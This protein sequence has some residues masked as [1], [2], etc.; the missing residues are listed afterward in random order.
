MIPHLTERDIDDS[1]AYKNKPGILRPTIDNFVIPAGGMALG[2][3]FQALNALTNIK[4]EP[5]IYEIK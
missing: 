1:I 5:K 3:A 2:G 4:R